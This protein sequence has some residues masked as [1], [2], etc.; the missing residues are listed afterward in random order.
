NESHKWYWVGRFRKKD[1]P[2][3]KPSQWL[4]VEVGE[5]ESNW[6]QEDPLLVRVGQATV[7]VKAG[8]NAQTFSEVVRIL[9]ALC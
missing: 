4:S 3:V 9:V 8:F 7:E 5:P 1:T 2:A 6:V